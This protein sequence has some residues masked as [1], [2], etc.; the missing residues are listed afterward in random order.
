[1]INVGRRS[2]RCDRLESAI[3][4]PRDI[5]ALNIFI[6]IGQARRRAL[7]RRHGR[8]ASRHL[9]KD[10]RK[11]AITRNNYTN[12]FHIYIHLPS[13]KLKLISN[14][15]AESQAGLIIEYRSRKAPRSVIIITRSRVMGTTGA[16]FVEP[17]DG[18]INTRERNNN[19]TRWQSRWLFLSGRHYE[20]SS[21]I[22]VTN[23]RIV[24]LTLGPVSSKLS[25]PR[26]RELMPV[27]PRR[28]TR[29]V[30]FRNRTAQGRDRPIETH[31]H[32][33]TQRER[34]REEASELALEAWIIAEFAREEKGRSASERARASSNAPKFVRLWA[35]DIKPVVLFR[36]ASSVGVRRCTF[37]LE[38]S[39][40][41]LCNSLRGV[42]RSRRPCCGFISLTRA[43]YFRRHPLL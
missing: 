25:T 16:P 21:W 34:E 39:P 17:N 33:H 4:A 2:R 27:M 22:N 43:I 38:T 5:A 3:M 10:N 41:R 29:V 28:R 37:G 20:L 19:R 18:H 23:A 11:F 40:R 9:S 8:E 13:R 26:G 14:T 1:M 7:Q 30:R 24:L 35:N 12:D 42:I 31:T 32:T 36:F 15:I 6:V